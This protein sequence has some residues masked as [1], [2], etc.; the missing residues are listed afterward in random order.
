MDSNEIHSP[1]ATVRRRSRW[2]RS[3]SPTP[4]S[5][6]QDGR[7][8]STYF[9]GGHFEALFTTRLPSVGSCIFFP[10]FSPI[11][12]KSFWFVPVVTS[13]KSFIESRT[14]A[15]PT[16]A[17]VLGS[18]LTPNQLQHDLSTIPNMNQ[19]VNGNLISNV[20]SIAQSNGIPNPATYGP[21]ATPGAFS[22]LVYLYA[23]TNFSLHMSL[24]K[25]VRIREQLHLGFRLEALNFLNHPF[26]PL[27]SS[28]PTGNTFG[29][30]SSTVSAS[31]SG[32]FNRVVLLRAYLSW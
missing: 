9:R 32:S 16:V 10:P 13:A 11:R 18:G 25:E 5:Q 12:S 2:A 29:Q 23:T 31:G 14:N 20:S 7:D 3:V 19:V 22:Q 30:V 27:G 26:F 6:N 24:S 4:P 21:A 28:T 17:V 1:P 8:S 15:R